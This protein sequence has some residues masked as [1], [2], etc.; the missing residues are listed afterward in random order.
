[1]EIIPLLERIYDNLNFD[2]LDDLNVGKR[3]INNYLRLIINLGLIESISNELLDRNDM[4]D[5]IT[6]NM[7]MEHFIEEVDKVLDDKQ[8]LIIHE[9]Y[10]LDN[11]KPQFLGTVGQ[12]HGF[13]R[14]RV[15]QI[16]AKAIKN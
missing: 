6:T 7:L 5:S 14:E 3:K 8:R 10:G 15:R 2:K 12:H 1:M 13:T 9:R 11:G 16:E 4:E